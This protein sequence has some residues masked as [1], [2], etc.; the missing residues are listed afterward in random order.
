MRS[1]VDEDR[2]LRGEH[3]VARPQVPV[4]PCGR[5][6]VVV[7]LLGDPIA[8]GLDHA[9]IGPS[10]MPHVHRFADE[11]TNPLF[12]EVATPRTLGVVGLR[13]PADPGVPRQPDGGSPKAP[14]PVEC[15]I[16]SARPRSAAAAGLRRCRRQASQVDVVR[17]H[18]EHLH[19][20]RA[21]VRLRLGQPPQPGGLGLEVSP[22]ASA[23]VFRC[24]VPSCR[25]D[26]TATVD[27]SR[28]S[29]RSEDAA[30]P[31]I[32]SGGMGLG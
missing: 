16:A 24:T 3:D 20:T 30:P 27:G 28:S 6:V 7:G 18:V 10:E 23:R 12:G 2:A 25:V 22:G 13:L 17:S 15:V 32:T 26:T 21:T 11:W 4:D 8:D 31:D 1:R 14:A 5:T 9:R 29:S 19:H